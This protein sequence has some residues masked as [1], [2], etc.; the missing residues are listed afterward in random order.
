MLVYLYILP[1]ALIIDLVIGEYPASFHPV[2]WIGNVIS[3]LLK[4]APRKGSVLQFIYGVAI[5]IIA[6]ALFTV[7]VFFL[8]FYLRDWSTVV[9]IIVAA[10]FL[11]STFSIKTLYK[12]GNNVKRLLVE[13]KIPAARR[14]TSY[15]VSRDTKKLNREQ[16]ASAIVEMETESITDSLV[17]PLF[18][19][20][21]FGVP[22]AIAYRVINTFDSRIG[23]R[24]EYEYT[25]KFAARLDDILNFVP[26]RL[27]GLLVVASAYIA[28][29]HGRKAWRTL[30]SDHNKTASPNAGWTMSAAA[31]ALDIRLEKPGHY[32]LGHTGREPDSSSI[33]G[34][35]QLMI[36]TCLLW[37]CISIGIIGVRYAF[38]A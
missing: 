23:Y 10:L 12:L 37:C 33:S 25:G 35:L 19:L 27:A 13:G 29:K 30:L 2:T 6:V 24:G 14:E 34:G 5:V 26:A 7:P 31:G 36:V 21:I 4:P 22:G 8:L 3:L 9:F 32:R 38:T 15:L 1:L 28:R 18:Y 16:I 20:L 17:A 11:K